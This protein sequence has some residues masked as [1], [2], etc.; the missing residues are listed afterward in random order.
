MQR[1]AVIRVL[2]DPLAKELLSADIPARLAYT[3]SDGFPRVVPIGFYWN[4]AHFVLGTAPNAPKV[5][6]LTRRPKVALTIDT[7]TQPPNVLLVRGTAS[8]EVVDG[9]PPEFLDGARKLLP[10]KKWGEFEAQARDLYKQMARIAIVPDWAKLLDFKS[11]FPSPIEE[12]V[13]AK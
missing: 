13:R 10:V 2:N 1:E 9:V 5:R 12:L 8:V 7:N 6:A 11:R 3:G 4:G